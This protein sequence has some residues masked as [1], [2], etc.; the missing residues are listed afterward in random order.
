MISI[1]IILIIV[2]LNINISFDDIK[3]VYKKLC[4]H[5]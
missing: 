2:I 1:I 3:Y 4:K 5:I